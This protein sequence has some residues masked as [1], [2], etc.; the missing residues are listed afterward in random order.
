[1]ALDIEWDNGSIY[2]DSIN[3]R[4]HGGKPGAGADAIRR[5]Q[6]FAQSK[7]CPVKLWTDGKKL[8]RYYKQLGF[9]VANK[10]LD[11]YGDADADMVWHG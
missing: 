2:I 1:M 4:E 9:K 5:V 10:H 7:R 11:Q 6:A 3:R 8:I